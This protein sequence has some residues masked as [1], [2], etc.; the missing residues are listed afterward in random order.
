MIPVE[1]HLPIPY[2]STIG[3]AMIGSVTDLYP[4][5]FLFALTLTHHGRGNRFRIF[6]SGFVCILL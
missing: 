4:E 5:I 1:E 6:K 3:E 2:N